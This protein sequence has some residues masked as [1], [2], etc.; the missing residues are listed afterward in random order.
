MT[1]TPIALLTDFGTRDIYV[2]VMKAVIL[3]LNPAA[4]L[5]DLTNRIEPQNVRQG[6]L[7]LMNAYRYFPKGTVF[8]VVV[9]PGVGTQ[10]RPIAVQ[11]GGYSFVA[12]DNGLLSYALSGFDDMKV[13]EIAV[14]DDADISNT[15]HGRD[16]FAPMAAKLSLGEALENLGTIIPKMVTLPA[17]QLDI[18]NKQVVGEVVHIDRFGNLVTSIGN[19]RWVTGERLI[20]NPA[21]GTGTGSAI[22]VYAENTITLLHDQQMVGI[23]QTY[24]EAERG[25]LLTLVGSTAFLEISVN[26]GSAAK[27][28]DAVIGDRV[29]LQIGEIDAAVRD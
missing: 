22:P 17:P 7:A 27:R 4:Q 24:S 15:F 12:P 14:P 6:A 21:F 13:V 29:E 28:L 8:L 25:G 11:A 19:L 2:G 3:S 1:N 18:V 9:D 26:Q 5:I 20:L 23:R 16:V 10:R